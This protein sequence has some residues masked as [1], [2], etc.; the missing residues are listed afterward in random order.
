MLRYYLLQENSPGLIFIPDIVLAVSAVHPDLLV[1]LLQ[2]GHALPGLG[3]LSLL[4]ALP[5][6]PVDEGSLRN[7][8]I[9]SVEKEREYLPWR[10]SG[11]TCGPA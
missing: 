11:R 3:E 8:G 9:T 7:I 10:T 4:H 2:G 6:V 5:D 1:V